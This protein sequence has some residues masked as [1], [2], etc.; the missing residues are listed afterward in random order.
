MKLTNKSRIY[1]DYN[2][3]APLALSFAEWIK[4]SGVLIFGNPSSRHLTGKKSRKLIREA[5]DFLFTTFNLPQ[6]Q[7]DCYFHSGATEALNSLMK[8]FALKC[9]QQKKQA[10]YYLFKTDHS[11]IFNQI[12]TL[13]LLGHKVTI[14]ECDSNGE[15]NTTEVIKIIEQDKTSKAFLNFTYVNNETGVVWDLQQAAVIKQATGCFVQVDAVQS[16]GKIKEFTQLAHELDSYT[17][18]A[19]KFGG[20]KGAG[21]SFLRKSKEIAALIEGGNQQ[22]G[23]R[24]GTENLFGIVSCQLALQEMLEKFNYVTLLEAKEYFEDRLLKEFG[25]KLLIVGQN[26]QQR[27]ANTT[28]FIYPDID[29]RISLTALDIVGF[30]VSSGPACSSGIL[31]A[32]RV[33]LALGH[34]EVAAKNSLRVSFSPFIKKLDVEKFM[35]LFIETLQRLKK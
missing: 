15:I 21:F 24:S 4:T 17:Y 14:L 20:T 26:A 5:T 29:A 1:L 22:L 2:A 18:S 12:E 25:S 23:L 9:M 3:T 35:P 6:D 10:H 34:D 27:A 33:V 13:K 7:F 11:C 31:K 30:D 16:I 28:C 8:G 19:H 32:S